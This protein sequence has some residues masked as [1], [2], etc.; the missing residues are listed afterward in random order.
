VYTKIAMH[1]ETRANDNPIAEYVTDTAYARNFVPQLSPTPQRLVAALAGVRPPPEEDFDYCELGSGQGDTLALLAA[2][3]PRARFVGV[4]FNPEHVAF[5][6]GLAAQAGLS[7]VRFLE[8]DFEALAAEDLPPFDFIGAHGVLSWVSPAKRAAVL[9]FAAARL[10]PGGLFYASYNALP[11]WAAIEPLRRLMLEHVARTLPAGASS[12]ER[13]REGFQLLQRLLD[14]NVGYFANHPTARSMVLLMQKA[15]LPYVVHEYFH[16]HWQPMYFADVAREM[17]S[18][19]LQFLGQLPLHQNVRELAVPPSLRPMIGADEGRVAFESLKDFA[20]NELFRSDVYVKPPAARSEE[21]TR[22]YF[23]QTRFGTLTNNAQI[24]RQA[25]L[26]FY[27]LTFT[28]PVYDPLIPAIAQG[29][30]SATE[31]AGRPDLAAF[32]ARRIGDCLQNLTLGG[33]VVPMRAW[34]T[35]A[36]A[37][38]RLAHVLPYNDRAL[39]DAIAGEGPLVLASPVTG[40][41]LS[42]SLLEAICLRLLTAVDPARRAEWIRALA[43]ARAQPI[44]VGDKPIKDAEKLVRAVTKE[45]D[46]FRTVAVPKLIELGILEPLPS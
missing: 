32:G 21:A 29:S 35:A 27:T 15:G 6:D 23:E 3:S 19:G 7:N 8:R 45:L 39:Q 22:T 12:L 44:V 37:G 33:Q 41:G 14:A 16:V 18:H 24:K 26:P 28:G 11:G 36:S 2:A 1:A 10:K 13:A 46:A 38:S 5:A 31:L 4:D 43:Q 30:A 20:T 42:I 40:M 9:A 34:P 25:R 17:S